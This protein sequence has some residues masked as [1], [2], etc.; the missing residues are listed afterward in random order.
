MK[1]LF[2]LI[3]SLLLYLLFAMNTFK[4]FI[5]NEIKE[6]S[7][8]IKKLN[9]LLSKEKQ[10]Y[11]MTCLFNKDEKIKILWKIDN[12]VEDDKT[13]Q[14]KTLQIELNILDKE[15]LKKD[16]TYNYLLIPH[17]KDEIY[18]L[19]EILSK[20]TLSS[21]IEILVQILGLYSKVDICQ[22]I[23]IWL[24]S[25]I[26]INKEKDINIETM[27]DDICE[28]INKNKSSKT[29]N[30]FIKELVSDYVKRRIKFLLSG[31]IF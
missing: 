23:I 13:E 5:N 1:Y 7:N 8:S 21:P 31:F 25:L 26:K 24:N 29:W 19:R 15:S 6:E 2:I 18:Q 22:D 16:N 17:Y 3:H 10:T 11:K 30:S 27:I 4:L 28:H 12:I 20:S 9:K 14:K